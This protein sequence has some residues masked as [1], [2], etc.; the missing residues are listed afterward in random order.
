MGGPNVP[1]I[2]ALPK[3]GWHPPPFLTM[4]KCYNVCDIQC[5]MQLYTIHTGQA[6]YQVNENLQERNIKNQTFSEVSWETS[7]VQ[8]YH[9][10]SSLIKIYIVKQKCENMF[11]DRCLCAN[12]QQNWCLWIA[13]R[14]HHHKVELHIG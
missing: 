13:A 14:P 1:K 3:L 10:F 5:V 7:S 6:Y 4:K 2:L 9:L 11:P 12:S 8:K